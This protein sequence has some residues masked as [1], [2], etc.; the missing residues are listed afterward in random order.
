MSETVYGT[1]GT[2][3]HVQGP[4]PRSTASRCGDDD[5][6]PYVQE[7]IDLLN[8]IRDGKP[9]NELKNVTDTTFTAILGRNAS[10]AAAT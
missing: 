6:R 10:Y 3:H 7:H 1:K 8:S 9:L 5:T 4:V 2:L